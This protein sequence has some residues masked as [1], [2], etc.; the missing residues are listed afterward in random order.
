MLWRHAIVSHISRVEM[1]W[2]GAG[3]TNLRGVILP[4]KDWFLKV[5]WTGIWALAD[6]VRQDIEHDKYSY[7]TTDVNHLESRVKLL[8]KGM[9]TAR[10][11]KGR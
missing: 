11:T 10:I 8:N 5:S 9:Q 6:Y 4:Y 7:S 1:L 3:V 2:T